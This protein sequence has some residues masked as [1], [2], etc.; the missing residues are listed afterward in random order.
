MSPIY[1]DILDINQ[2]PSNINYCQDNTS[3]GKSGIKQNS[4]GYRLNKILYQLFGDKFLISI[5]MRNLQR[6]Q[7]TNWF[8][9]WRYSNQQALINNGLIN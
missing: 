8:I 2:K 9:Y 4:K 5:A 1:H 7:D 6:I 3:I